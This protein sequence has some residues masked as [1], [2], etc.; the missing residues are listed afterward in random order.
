[1]FCGNI[2]GWTGTRISSWRTTPSHQCER[3]S[4]P[5]HSCTAQGAILSF[6]STRPLAKEHRSPVTFLAAELGPLHS[7]DEAM[8]QRLEQSAQY[9]GQAGS[10]GE[11]ASAECGRRALSHPH[12]AAERGSHAPASEAAPMSTILD[13]PSNLCY[14]NAAVH[15][16]AWM[17]HASGLPSAML[18]L[19]SLSTDTY[20]PCTTTLGPFLS[21]WSDIHHQ[22]DCAERK[23]AVLRYAKPPAYL[24]P[25]L[26]PRPALVFLCISRTKVM[27]WQRLRWMSGRGLYSNWWMTGVINTLCM[28]FRRHANYSFCNSSG[29]LS[30]RRALSKIRILYYFRLE[31]FGSCQFLR[32]VCSGLTRQVFHLGDSLWSGHSR[33]ALSAGHFG[34]VGRRSTWLVTDN[35]RPTI[36]A[37]SADI[38]IIQ[39][40][41]YIVGCLPIIPAEDVWQW[42]A[43]LRR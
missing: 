13:N 31:S 25:A 14:L 24:A 2:S 26:R 11:A 27:Q 29:T 12:G 30:L 15:A 28:L 38:H 43:I 20:D 35:G 7:H 3:S 23:M 4:R 9:P 42:D 33:A 22:Q 21:T 6:H 32:G 10:H 5:Y 18:L 8:R 19:S 16:I 41:C 37:T 40:S 39:R 17:G 36:P 1:M 34:M